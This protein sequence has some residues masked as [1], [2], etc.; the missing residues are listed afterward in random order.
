[1]KLLR[2]TAGDL[3]REGFPAV[4]TVNLTQYWVDGRLH[5]SSGPAVITPGG[6]MYFWRGLNIPPKI[7]DECDAYNYKDVL[8]IRNIELRRA[9]TEKVGF[10]QFILDAKLQDKGAGDFKG[11]SLYRIADNSEQEPDDVITFIELRN[12]TP[13]VNKEYKMYYLRV[14]PNIDTV[15]EGVEWSFGIKDFKY[16]EQT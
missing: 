11:C 10:G 7:W 12:S 2:S 14:P 8:N 16:V 5:R 15:K 6:K 4:Q 3:H 1:M 9:I 13:E